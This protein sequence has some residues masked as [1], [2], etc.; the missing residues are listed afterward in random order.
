MVSELRVPIASMKLD[1]IHIRYHLSKLDVY[2]NKPFLEKI[3]EDHLEFVELVE[4]WWGEER[5]FGQRDNRS[6]PIQYFKKPY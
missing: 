4:D 5:E 3:G 1:D 2:L 6:Y